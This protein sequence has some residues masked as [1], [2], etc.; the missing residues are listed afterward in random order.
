MSHLD[1]TI[2]LMTLE[3]KMIQIEKVKNTS[4]IFVYLKPS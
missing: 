2:V 4:E 1:R 3:E